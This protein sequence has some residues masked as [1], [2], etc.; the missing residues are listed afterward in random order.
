MALP[1][2]RSRLALGTMAACLVAAALL[3]AA[4]FVMASRPPAGMASIGG[5]FTL[6]D[7]DGQTVTQ[8]TVAGRPFVMFFGYTHCPDVCPTTLT[9]LTG[10]LKE[11]GPQAKLTALFVTVDPERDTPAV[12]KDYLSSFDPRIRGLTGSPASVAAA[13]KAYKVYA[14]KVPVGSD[15]DYSMD[16]TAVVYLMDRNGRFL[17]ALNLDQPPAA[18]AAAIKAAL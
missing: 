14:R 10:V 3:A 13:E 7:Q 8:E 17:S 11:L 1:L 18:A 6:A 12:L 5:P 9:D 16:H 15:G 4:T 2:P